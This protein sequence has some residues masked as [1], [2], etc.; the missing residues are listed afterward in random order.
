[1][2]KLYPPSIEGTLPAFCG[3]TMTIPFSM[4]RT[5]SQN[6]VSRIAVKVKSIQS[7][8]L[9]Y[10]GYTSL[11]DY[12]TKQIFFKVDAAGGAP[13]VQPG[14]SYKI[15]IAY[16]DQQG[17]VGYYSS[18]GIIK[19]TV[20]PIVEID[21][22]KI[23][24]LNTNLV[25]YTG[26]Y[27]QDYKNGIGDVSE[28]VYSYNFCVYD[29]MGNLF[30]TSGE[31]L[32]NHEL[33]DEVYESYDTFTINENLEEN[34]SYFIQYNVTTTNGLQASSPRYRIIQQDTVDPDIKSE[35]VASMN[36]KNGY[37][38]I[39]LVGGKND[40][41][42]EEIAVGTFIITRASSE[43]N[44]RTWNPVLKFVLYG[45]HPSRWLWKDFTIQ[46]GFSYQ[47]ALQQYNKES[48]LYSNKIYSNI[49]Q[50]TFEDC[51]LFD[52]KRQL[53]IR[54]NPKISSFKQDVLE[55]KTETLGGKYPIISRNGNVYYK[56]FP[57]SGLISYQ[58]DDE[59]LFLDE[60]ELG[61]EKDIDTIKRTTTLDPK[62]K[63]KDE[64][65]FNL[66]DDAN[67]GMRLQ[68][69]YR[70]RD[71]ASS[72]FN[73]M[74]K[75]DKKLKTTD[76]KD[77]NI[78]AERIFKL[79]VLEFLTDGQPK[80]F[81]SPTEGNYLVRVMN[82]SLSPEDKVGRMLHT[83]S[84]T[85]YEIAE[86]SYFNLNDMGIISTEDPSS[87]QLR[88]E[89]IE[90]AKQDLEVDEYG[91]P[92]GTG[93]IIYTPSGVKL[94]QHAMYSIDCKDMT[95]GDQ[96]E[97]GNSPALGARNPLTGEYINTIITIGNTG[98]Y[99]AVFDHPIEYLALVSYT[100]G[101]EIRQGSITYS[102]Y[103]STFNQFDTYQ[104]IN[105]NDIPIK[106]YYGAVDVFEDIQDLKHVIT[107]FYLLHFQKRDEL[108]V[109]SYADY[110]GFYT[111]PSMTVRVDLD[112]LYIYKVYNPDEMK[113]FH[114]IDG[115]TGRNLGSKIISK[116]YING[117]EID[118][119]E[120]YDFELRK[121][122]NIESLVITDGVVADIAIQRKEIQYKLEE[123]NSRVLN[124]KRIYTDA[125]QALMDLI[126][127]E[128]SGE[129]EIDPYIY[130]PAG[131][132]PNEMIANTMNR[133]YNLE[134]EKLL[135]EEKAAYNNYLES[136]KTALIALEKEAIDVES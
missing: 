42:T 29:D 58:M 54:F 17:I 112:P 130:N 129:D 87:L 10:S 1:M 125:H 116:V 26:H 11:V 51:F 86:P 13:K 22:L 55:S 25:S 57:I 113:T 32:H 62:V 136:I 135:F 44:F 30:A 108:T 37:V 92:H 9:I 98:A 60:E 64:A 75:S 5:V 110:L 15:Q 68:A 84:C 123:T 71:I 35:L 128:Y 47:Y 65:Y 21:N 28:K 133:A 14:R 106:Q 102:Y 39:A 61:F 119:T 73:L 120:T 121:P 104:K 33:D 4:N 90:L 52:G 115:R 67:V 34:V 23:G 56:E 72:D 89:T 53:R 2:A 127:K 117:K 70:M 103:G 46:H 132:T 88:W 96:I 74:S 109:Y 48:G 94:N 101:Q 97:F 114:Y 131:E 124:F 40:D 6:A 7:N 95:P 18:V 69:S 27:L 118:I 80:L 126:A 107:G 45:E 85:A 50:A 134:L 19:C 81:R 76:L 122:E 16:V 83:F 78:L 59:H 79:R 77:H 12:E 99:H 111:S 93:Q 8:S 20:K 38:N 63:F 82:S 43:D 49:L 100:S 91:Q 31:Q 36:E 24:D 66:L 41:G 3:D 105:V